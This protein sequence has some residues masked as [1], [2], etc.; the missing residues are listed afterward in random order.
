MMATVEKLK[1]GLQDVLEFFR[2]IS[3][4]PSAFLAATL[5]FGKLPL[6]S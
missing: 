2:C 4:S 3:I 1:L 5:G 6:T